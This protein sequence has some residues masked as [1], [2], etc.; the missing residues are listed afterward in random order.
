MQNLIEKPREGSNRLV[1]TGL[2][3]LDRRVFEMKLTKSIRGE[4]E[5]TE[6]IKALTKQIKIFVV[7]AENW[8]P[9]SYP[10]DLLKAN[11]FLLQQQKGELGEDVVIEKGAI[12]KGAIR[13]GKGTVIKSGSYLEGPLWLGEKNQI[14]PNTYLRPATMI[15]DHC[16]I[17]AGVEIKNSIIGSGSQ[18]S[19]LSYIGDSVIGHHCHLGAGTII[20]NLRFDQRS[21]KSEV[22][23]EMIDTGLRKWGAVLGDKVQTGV[24]VSIM[25][26]VFIDPEIT[27]EPNLVVKKNI[28]NPI[29]YD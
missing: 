29:F 25:P 12:L 26:G 8:I 7:E 3:F 21:I 9:L 18:V 6:A 17:G 28:R 2:Y 10:W 23:G 16:R 14:G 13:I 22:K 1:N 20:A 27:I 15:G 24:N 4:F 11:Q 19:H 5:L